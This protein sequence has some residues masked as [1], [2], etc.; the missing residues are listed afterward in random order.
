MDSTAAAAAYEAPVNEK[1][2]MVDPFLVEALMNSRHRLTILRME[3]DIQKFL[4]SSDQDQFEFQ[5]FPTSYLRLAAHRVAQ[6]YGLLTMV[7]D[8]ALDGSGNRILVRRTAESRY[9]TVCLSEVPAKLSDGD[10]RE[11]V[12]IVIRPRPNKGFVNEGSE[13][14]I[15]R[16]PP[17]SV[18]ERKEDY[19]RARARIFSGPSSPKT[20]DSSSQSTMVMKST[21]V[22][23]DENEGFRNSLVDPEK[24][25]SVRDGGS[26]SRVAILRD[27][28][29]ERTDPDYD[30]SYERYV[31][32]LPTNQ[33][34]SLAPFN[35]QEIQLPF[36]QYDAGYL[37]LYQMRTQ[38]PLGYGLPASPAMNPFSA[39]GSNQTSGDPAY[40]QWPSAAMMY[41]HSFEPLRQTVFQAP[42]CQQPLSFDYPQ[43][44]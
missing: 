13:N 20:G 4:Q 8:N 33:A 5:H 35:V 10:K 9:P 31:R 23:R 21:C 15:K 3:L 12:K 43:N 38:A 42:F 17:R 22:S 28:E 18:E 41:A 40:I 37:Q 6:H 16:S 27:R 44:H 30:R 19:D 7:H 26:S 11:N 2:S 1:E 39:T 14:G 29:K 25:G 36:L 34:F 32:S 24:V